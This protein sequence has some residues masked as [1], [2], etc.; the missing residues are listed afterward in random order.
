MMQ[1]ARLGQCSGMTPE[2]RPQ[3]FGYEPRTVPAAR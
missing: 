2:L 3:Y 1:D